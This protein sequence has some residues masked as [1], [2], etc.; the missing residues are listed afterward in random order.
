MIIRK[1]KQ[2]LSDGRTVGPIQNRSPV[3]ELVT[4][5]ILS[6]CSK[7]HYF[8][9]RSIT[10]KAENSFP[11]TILVFSFRAKTLHT[12]KSRVTLRRLGKLHAKAT[13]TMGGAPWKVISL[14]TLQ[15]KN[16]SET[17]IC[18]INMLVSDFTYR[19]SQPP[20]TAAR[21]GSAPEMVAKP[22]SN[23]RLANWTLI[24]V[25]SSM[26]CSVKKSVLTLGI[27]ETKVLETVLQMIYSA[28]PRTFYLNKIG[29][30]SEVCTSTRG[31]QWR[32]EIICYY[33]C[34]RINL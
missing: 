3:I 4:S 7:L 25:L 15:D 6:W 8:R 2:D 19:S 24:A 10:L 12:V 9:F 13:F 21:I 33:E 27:W 16:S 26:L 28:S 34:V 23:K 11:V 20:G 18:P 1:A 31:I 22:S 5:W 29:W 14:K 17:R 30:C 32:E